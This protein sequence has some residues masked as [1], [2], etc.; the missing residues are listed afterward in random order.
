MLS[1]GQEVTFRV[2]ADNLGQALAEFAVEKPN[3]LSHALQRKPLV[4]QFADDRDFGQIIH[5]VQTAMP[6]ALRL[7]HAAL[8][9]PLELA[10]RDPRQRDYLLRCE[11]IL[12]DPPNVFET[13]IKS[14]VSNILGTEA[15]KSSRESVE[16][17][18]LREFMGG[19]DA[20]TA[21]DKMD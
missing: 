19:V 17:G 7:H 9:P 21:T 3:D 15:R 13:I 6:F 4:P 18:L 5:R 10:G 11:P 16:I 14:N 8:I 1:V 20:R 12:H 2:A